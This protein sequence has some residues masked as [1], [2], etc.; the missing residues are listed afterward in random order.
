MHPSPSDSSNATQGPWR[1][2][3]FLG[4]DSGVAIRNIIRTDVFA[5]LKAQPWLRI[6][7]FGPLVDDEF[8]R[9]VAAPNVFVEK[10]PQKKEGAILALLASIRKEI[11]ADKA[12]LF[13][14][15]SKRLL[16]RGRSIRNFLIY[17]VFRIK[18]PERVRSALTRIQKLEERFAP[19]HAAPYFDRYQPDLLFTTTI[20][21]RIHNL[22]WFAKKRRVP[23]AAFILSWDNPTSKGPFPVRPERVILWNE[24]LRQELM[25]HHDCTENELYV[26]GVPQFDI[27]AQHERYRSRDDF[28]RR[29]KLD[30]RLPLI[31][32]TTGTPETAPFDD[33]VVELLY[34]RIQAGALRQKV[35]LLVRLHPKDK[36]DFYRRFEGLPGLVLQLPGRAGSTADSW[37]PTHDDMYGLAELMKYT[38][39]NVNVA[40]TIT[41]DAA[42]F[43]T[44]VVNIAFD[45][46]ATK[47][48]LESCVRYYDYEHYK[49]IVDTGGVRIA[50]NPDEMM[51][52]IQAY[53]DD[54]SL[55]SEGRR[56]IREEQCWK[57]DGN[58]G[59]R[60][61]EYLIRLMGEEPVK[62]P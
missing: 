51:H 36:I 12:Q 1:R 15:G 46:L 25:D 49:R 28:H 2:T 16:K 47:P 13:T 14:F 56:R 39:V 19:T 26:S 18:S 57:L 33:Q 52:A 53:L 59:R 9:E 29:W 50:R 20:Y 40:S 8:R 21:S 55:E 6:V 5:V 60:I 45:G 30:P 22:E 23:C 32:Y 34:K 58:S 44:P 17:H 41:I 61:A 42:A 3:I 48:Y 43:D 24:I 35:Q 4:M 38:A 37:N 7:I 11:W 27:Y 31:T 10:L 54:P 62:D